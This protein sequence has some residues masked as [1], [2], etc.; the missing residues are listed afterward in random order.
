MRNERNCMFHADARRGCLDVLKRVVG[1]GMGTPR[2]KWKFQKHSSVTFMGVR[3]DTETVDGRCRVDGR[4]PSVECL[5]NDANSRGSELRDVGTRNR[6]S[7]PTL[8]L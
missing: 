3:T 5:V 8:G 1:V 4:P 7:F 2:A 6:G